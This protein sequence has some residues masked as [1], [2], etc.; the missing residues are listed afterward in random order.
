MF[1]LLLGVKG[2]F[3]VFGEFL[4]D[5]IIWVCEI[6]FWGDGF[7]WVVEIVGEGIDV[8]VDVIGFV[9]L[10]VFRG[11]EEVIIVGFCN[12][13]IFGEGGEDFEYGLLMKIGFGIDGEM[14]DVNF[15]VVE[16]KDWGLFK[17]FFF[18]SVLIRVFLVEFKDVD[19]EVLILEVRA[20]VCVMGLIFLDVIV[21]GE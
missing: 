17:I 2:V 14:L 4:V 3:L 1:L 21:R 19:D 5:V 10:V 7:V 9:L 8:G 12:M 18:C 6:V 15:D 13:G 11:L 20:L 16:D